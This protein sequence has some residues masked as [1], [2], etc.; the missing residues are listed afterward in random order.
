MRLLGLRDVVLLV[1]RLGELG[2]LLEV[3][4]LLGRRDVGLA[5]RRLLCV[6]VRVLR[7]GDA[8]V[9]RVLPVAL[10]EVEGQP[11]DAA[12]LRVRLLRRLDRRLLLLADG[13]DV[14]VLEVASVHRVV[15]PLLPARLALGV[16]LRQLRL[17]RRQ[18]LRLL[19]L[20]GGE[21]SLKGGGALRLVVGGLGR[22]ER[23]RLPVAHGVLAG[24]LELAGLRVVVEPHLAGRLLARVDQLV[25]RRR[26]GE[27][28]GLAIV[29][30]LELLLDLEVFDSRELLLGDRVVA[31]AVD[32]LD[33]EGVG[34]PLAAVRLLPVV[35]E[36]VVLVVDA[37]LES[38]LVLAR[39]C[40]YEIVRQRAG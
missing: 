37:H 26:L 30:G 4:R 11:L 23:G 31:R 38:M 28:L 32:I 13:V 21:R 10:G 22:L 3:A 12:L 33:G 8:E 20:A 15:E 9:A 29:A 18:L 27:L 1:V 25:L 7:L 5:L 35:H 24:L 34:E 16:Q 39:L 19:V 36:R 2:S 40:L 6:H 14:A 17:A